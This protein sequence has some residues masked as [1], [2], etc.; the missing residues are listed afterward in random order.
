MAI[1]QSQVLQVQQA[2]AQAQVMAAVHLEHLQVPAEPLAALRK[3]QGQP[4]LPQEAHQAT[5]Q[6]IRQE[7]PATD[8]TSQTMAKRI[9]QYLAHSQIL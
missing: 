6:L 1:R 9:W 4:A 5:S 3:P 2:L 8:L 7:Q